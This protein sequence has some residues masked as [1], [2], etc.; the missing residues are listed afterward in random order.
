MSNSDIL[1]KCDMVLA[2]SADTVNYQFEEL[3][4]RTIIKKE[5]KLLVREDKDNPV[6]KTG[7]DK[8]F[9]NDLKAWQNAQADLYK[10][11]SEKNFDEFGKKLGEYNSKGV[12]YSYGWSGMINAPSITILQKDVQN[13][14]FK[15]NFSSGTLYN[16]A[17][18]TKQME[19]YDLKGVVYAFKVPVGRVEINSTEKILTPEAKGQAEKVI[20][21]SGLT[22]ADFTMESLFMDFE[23]ADIANFDQA[24][25]KFPDQAT[26]SLQISIQDY[27]KLIVAKSDNPFILGYGMSVKKI[28]QQSLFQP[29][30]VR[31][32]TS[33][34]DKPSCSAFNFLMMSG[35]TAFPSGQNVGILSSSLLETLDNL[36]KFDGVLGIDYSYF[37]SLL[38]SPFF[39]TISKTITQDFQNPKS[40]LT[41]QSG[42]TEAE[43][44]TSRD[45]DDP[46]SDMFKK[47]EIKTF[48]NV[49]GNTKIYNLNQSITLESDFDYKVQIEVRPW[50][51]LHWGRHTEGKFIL[52]TSGKQDKG[53]DGHLGQQGFVKI[54]FKPGS[55]GQMQISVDQTQPPYLGYEYQH[56]NSYGGTPDTAVISAMFAEA[57]R[58]EAKKAAITAAQQ[59][60]KTI[61]SVNDSLKPLLDSLNN[62]KIIL[63]LGQVY[64]FSNIRLYK[65]ENTPD[66]PVMFNV[67][68]SPVS[69]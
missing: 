56:Y 58:K 18:P 68:Y 47:T 46:P 3:W 5:W 17:D 32:S 25:S 55:S 16:A 4:N 10:L 66:N 34:S 13:L 26:K 52:S 35:G 54:S 65:N 6:V 45:T 31:Y 24:D 60:G 30:S 27:F 9:D 64:S 44:N 23:N 59:I 1:A 33:Y 2:V 50:E 57:G 41:N 43:S 29:T 8:N 39:D 62:G 38:I 19:T 20:R 36:G 48:V 61:D 22:Q 40:N 69:N 12:L 28:E 53:P 51:V 14:L 63:P 37:S 42:T 49:N 7:D 21:D 15:I 67:K 11:F